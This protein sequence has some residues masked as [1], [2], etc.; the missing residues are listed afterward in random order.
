M[1][2]MQQR[3]PELWLGAKTQ[4]SP[5]SPSKKKKDASGGTSSIMERNTGLSDFRKRML[6]CVDEAGDADKEK[7]SFMSGIMKGAGDKEPKK[8]G[9]SPSKKQKAEYGADV[10]DAELFRIPYN[11][12]IQARQEMPLVKLLLKRHR[13]D[14]V[15]DYMSEQNY[16]DIAV[17]EAVPAL[18]YQEVSCCSVCHQVRCC[19]MHIKCV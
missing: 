17:G 9:K 6:L 8:A 1:K 13:N 14:E 15:G 4:G 18:Y 2:Y 19:N 3:V 11:R 7:G 16:Q 5:E 12:I 10:E